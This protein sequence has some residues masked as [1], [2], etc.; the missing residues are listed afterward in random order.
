MMGTVCLNSCCKYKGYEGVIH[1]ESLLTVRS[2]YNRNLRLEPDHMV[3]LDFDNQP[4]SCNLFLQAGLV[5]Y[6]IRFL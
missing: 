3:A 5:I 6:R 4:N 2:K 1:N